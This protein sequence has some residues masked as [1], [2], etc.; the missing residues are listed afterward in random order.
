MIPSAFVFLDAVPLT[1]TG[2]IDRGALPEPGK[3]RP[4]LDTPYVAPQTPVE[5][6]LARLW[7]EVLSLEKVGIHDNFWDLGG[8][9]LTA[10]RVVSRIIRAFQ[11]EMPMDALFASPTVADM[12][13]TVLNNPSSEEVLDRL[14]REVEAMSEDD[15]QTLLNHHDRMQ[16]H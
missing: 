12:A 14:L 5:K 1:P 8:H 11:I 3:L 16:T 10:A 7:A 13:K 6:N 2:K 4:S 15:A 9:S